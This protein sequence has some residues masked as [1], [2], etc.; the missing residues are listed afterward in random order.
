[1][2]AEQLEGLADHLE[3]QAATQCLLSFLFPGKA[4]LSGNPG[5]WQQLAFILAQR[6]QLRQALLAKEEEAVRRAWS[7]V[8][9]DYQGDMPFQHTLAVLYR[10]AARTALHPGSEDGHQ[11]YRSTA[12][13]ASLLTSEAFWD[14]FAD[15]RGVNSLPGGDRAVVPT[16][17]LDELFR[18]AL[19]SLLIPHSR[20]AGVAYASGNL[21]AA[22]I[23]FRCLHLCRS[24]EELAGT[25]RACD[26]VTALELDH[27]RLLALEELAE[28]L[29]DT[30]GL[31][32]VKEAEKIVQDPDAIRSLPR[33]IRKN[34]AGG[35]E[36]L[37]PF[38]KLGVPVVRVL[39][40]CLEWYNDWCYDL[41]ITK[42]FQRIK[43]LLE[44]ASLVA[45]QLI[46]RSIKARA[47]LPEN[48]AL[49]QHF[50]LH[51][52]SCDDPQQATS[53][54][55]EAL[56]WNPANENA[57]SLLAETAQ[58]VL[59]KQLQTAKE[60]LERRQFQQAY[61]I[62]DSLENQL[63]D[64]D[65]LRKIRAKVYF[66]HGQTLA[67]ELRFRE[68]LIK[69]QEAKR[70]EPNHPV[71]AEFLDEMIK[72]APEEDNLRHIHRGKKALEKEHFEEVIQACQEVSADSRFCGQACELMASAYFQR[73]IKAA[74]AKRFESAEK[75]LREAIHLIQDSEAQKIIERQLSAVLNAHAVQLVNE[76]Q[77][78]EKKFEKMAQV[79]LQKVKIA[80]EW[81][82]MIHHFDDLLTQKVNSSICPCCG[83]SPNQLPIVK[84]IV[85]EVIS[86][87][88]FAVNNTWN[89]WQKFRDHLCP[90]CNWNLDAI[91]SLKMKACMLLEEASRLD[92][93]NEAA[94]KNLSALRNM[95]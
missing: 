33:G 9:T 64:Q 92:P 73:G 61:E 68:A 39:R 67:A 84:E 50:L 59:F 90:S 65:T 42:D 69:A 80:L 37:Q 13:W 93:D 4:E 83:L 81:P 82:I 54:Y 23:H 76:A 3:N 79:I 56:A 18:E 66:E 85:S 20:S 87:G 34:Y 71:V 78:W 86:T 26:C 7:Q 28:E 52:F 91:Q 32:L 53:F 36:H 2:N 62:L 45:D 25:L 48:Q 10:D 15:S 46:S 95:L 17:L 21:A 94:R 41:Y 77:E 29:L 30:I 5:R 72:L 16:A 38:I 60:C 40:T 88:H 58:A 57:K 74:H 31:N 49:A 12:M 63:E 24:R 8:L 89:F 14:Y 1:M 43:M 44:P 6:P 19:K 11:V 35:T 27:V 70:W 47:H 51:G 22:A 55:E 75:D